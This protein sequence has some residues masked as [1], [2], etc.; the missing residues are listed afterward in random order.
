MAMPVSKMPWPV[1]TESVNYVRDAFYGWWIVVAAMFMLTLS[2]VSVFQGL[3]TMFVA[4]ERQFGWSRT[5]LSGA[6]SLSRVEGAVLGPFEGILID[7][8]GPRRM[9]VIGSAVTGLG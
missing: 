9:I 7:R 1:F 4:L 6:S 2:A 3:G 8:L 5:A